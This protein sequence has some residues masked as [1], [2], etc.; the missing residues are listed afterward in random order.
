MTVRRAPGGGRKPKP[1]AQKLLAGNPGKRELNL[2]EPD[3]T[4]VVT[5]IEPPEWLSELA[6]DMWHRVLPELLKEEVLKV[7]DLHNVE[8]FCAAYARWRQSEIEVEALGMV[9]E[10]SKGGYVKNPALSAGNE[11]VQ[12][13]IRVGSALGLDPSSRSALI[14]AAKKT[15]ANPFDELLS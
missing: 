13:M 3:F 8:V 1:T 11:A 5:H 14:G 4:P 9:V 2:N 10:G 7:T 15:E 12:Q 6:V